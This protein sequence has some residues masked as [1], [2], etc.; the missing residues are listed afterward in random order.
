MSVLQPRR[1]GWAVQLIGSKFVFLLFATLALSFTTL[2][3]A[4]QQP[5]VNRSRSFG[6]NACGPADP[7]YIRTASESGGIPMFLQHSEAGKAFQ[8][9]RESTKNNVSTILWATGSLATGSRGFTVPVDSTMQS[10]TIA[11]SVDTK[12]STMT[13]H[14]PSGAEV[15][16]G[17]AGVEITE[18]NCGR[19]I[20]VNSPETGKWDVRLK[21]SGRFWIQA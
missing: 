17:P 8:L 9:V 12:G 15:V 14:R 20:T 7:T 3:G 13:V 1:P 19:I 4:Q 5:Q 16:A 21:G 2:V 6:P 10:L 11:V 18:L